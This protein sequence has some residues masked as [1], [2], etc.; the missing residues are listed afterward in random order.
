MAIRSKRKEIDEQRVYCR[1]CMSLK[2]P[3]E[4]FVAVDLEID[5]N[6]FFSICKKCCDEIYNNYYRVE[7]DMARAIL[8][9]CRKINLR[10]DESA[11]ESTETHLKTMIDNG[12]SASGVIG[13]YKAKL[14]SS[15][16]NNFSDA[17][18]GFDLTF[19][20]SGISL[21]PS[22]P[23]D[24]S[25]ESYDLKQIWGDGFS[26]DDYQFLEREFSE[27]TKTH[28]CDTKAEKMLLKEI[29]HK[30][31]E[32]RKKRDESNG[33]GTTPTNLIKDLQ[34]L[35]KTASVDPA[36]TLLAN[37]GKNKD[38]F[39]AFV[40]IIEENEPA[41]YYSNKGLYKDFDGLDFYFKKYVTRP[42]KNFVTQ[43]RDF[44]VEVDDD[45]DEVIESE[46]KEDGDI[47]QSV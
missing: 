3:T 10:F 43:S 29:C 28:K 17:A 24:D 40:K 39:S 27:W 6:G 35:M 14:V 46:I 34:D 32:I 31:L 12:K 20:E 30:S 7:R 4:F 47:T 25:E 45:S 19:M 23:L 33:A 38:T 5:K 15:L 26:F 2:R 36:K 1:K 41:E 9:T 44:N 13:V 16:K 42:L 22:E 18:S 11:V 21:P 8:R 37:S